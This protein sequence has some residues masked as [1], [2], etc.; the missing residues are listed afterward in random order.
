MHSSNS[1]GKGFSQS[2]GRV[3]GTTHGELDLL[4]D[5]AGQAPGLILGPHEVRFLIA[6]LRGAVPSQSWCVSECFDR[7]GEQQHGS[8][9]NVHSRRLRSRIRAPALPDR[10]IPGGRRGRVGG[11]SRQCYAKGRLFSCPVDTI[12]I[13]KGDTHIHVKTWWAVPNKIPPINIR[14]QQPSRCVCVC[15]GPYLRHTHQSGAP[16]RQQPSAHAAGRAFARASRRALYRRLSPWLWGR[17][18]RG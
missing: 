3:D 15:S 6:A 11:E 13:G 12:C 2:L 18:C 10:R 5:L 1:T 9:G 7:A 8:I 17:T 4:V 14:Q 16:H